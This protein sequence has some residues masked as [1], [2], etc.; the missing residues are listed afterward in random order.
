MGGSSRTSDASSIS[1]PINSKIILTVGRFDVNLV[2]DLVE[3]PRLIVVG[4]AVVQVAS[5]SVVTATS[6]ARLKGVGTL[7]GWHLVR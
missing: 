2:D 3:G 5:R 1:T 7:R 4:A 6:N